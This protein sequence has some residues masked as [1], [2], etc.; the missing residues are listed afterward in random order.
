MENDQSISYYESVNKKY[1]TDQFDELLSNASPQSEDFLN[2]FIHLLEH[3]KEEELGHINK[4]ILGN[5]LRAA[6]LCNEALG[7]YQTLQNM[8][9]A[10]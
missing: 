4:S 1:I 6:A 5:D 7:A 3:L 2:V 10:E 9:T 8:I